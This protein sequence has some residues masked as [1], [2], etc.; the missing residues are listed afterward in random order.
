LFSFS[1]IGEGRDEVD[2]IRKYILAGTLANSIN[3]KKLNAIFK[4]GG[5]Q[6]DFCDF[7]LFILYKLEIIQ[8]PYNLK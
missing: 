1:S 5:S 8:I 4:A 3:K 2:I 7:N 6:D